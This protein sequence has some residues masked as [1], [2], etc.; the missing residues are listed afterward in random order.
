MKGLYDLASVATGRSGI[1][2]RQFKNSMATLAAT[3]ISQLDFTSV[4]SFVDAFHGATSS[5]GK[6]A[7]AGVVTAAWLNQQNGGRFLSNTV[8]V[9]PR[10]GDVRKIKMLK[11]PYIVITTQKEKNESGKGRHVD[12]T[13]TFNTA[14]GTHT[15]R[16][17]RLFGGNHVSRSMNVAAEAADVKRQ[18]KDVKDRMSQDRRNSKVF[19]S[20]R[21]QAEQAQASA[22]GISSGTSSTSPSPLMGY[23]IEQLME[24]LNCTTVQEGKGQVSGESAGCTT[25]HGCKA[26]Q[27]KM[28]STAV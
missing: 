10:G 24:D 4:K 14:T 28:K 11:E 9:N 17:D 27:C 12:F 2:S 7:V 18:Q 26:C 16:G 19:E 15:V 6:A 8:F 23:S 13:I 25:S 22:S 1:L 3:N 5:R 20:E 21:K